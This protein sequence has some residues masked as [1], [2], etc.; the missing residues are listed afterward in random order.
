MGQY[1]QHVKRMQTDEV[2]FTTSEAARE[3]G[4]SIDTLRRW[5]RQ[6]GLGPSESKKFGKQTIGLYT[7]NDIVGLKDHKKTRKLGRPKGT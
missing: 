5:K 2:Y 1:Q 4:I 3:V 6:F 7:L